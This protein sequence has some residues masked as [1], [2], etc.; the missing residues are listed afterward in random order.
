[1]T[2]TLPSSRRLPTSKQSALGDF[3]F[4]RGI[5]RRE[6]RGKGRGMRV[7]VQRVR[8]AAV[9]IGGVI[10]GEISQGVLVFVGIEETDA[11]EDVTWLSGKIAKMRIFADEE[12]R[13]NL[14]CGEVGGSA[15]VVSQFTLHASTKKGNR[16]SYSQAARPEIAIPLYEAF[17]AALGRELGNPVATGEFGADMQVSLINDGPVTIWMDSKRRE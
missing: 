10:R 8:E 1:M 5:D 12:G 14:A 17:I 11:I 4:H 2:F 15:L 9:R 3:S 6:A 13:M 7:L 16:P